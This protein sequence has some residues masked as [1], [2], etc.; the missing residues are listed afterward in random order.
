MME[1]H[2]PAF[3]R[4][5]SLAMPPPAATPFLDFIRR[6]AQELRADDRAPQSL[7]Q[8]NEMRRKLVKNLQT[9]WGPFPQKHAPL[10]PQ[11]LGQL[12]RDGYRVEKIVFQTRPGV[13]MPANAYVPTDDR[14]A[15][16]LPAVLCVHGHWQG[17]KQDPH[18]QARC[19]G[20]AKLGFFVLAVD[21]LGAGERAVGTELGEYH[22]EMTAGTLWPTGL[23]LSGLQVYENMRAVDYLTS[24]PEVDAAKIGITGASGGGNQTMYAGAYDERFKAVVPVCSVGNYQAYLGAAC[25]MCEV[26][27]GALQ[28]TEEWGVLALVAPRALLVISATRDAHQFS[29]GEAKKS[30]ALAAPVFAL[31]GK[32]KNVRH[33]TFESPHDYNQ[34]MREAMYGWMTLHLKGQGDGA[35][36]TEPA[37]KMDDPEELRCYPGKSRAAQYM[38]IPRLAAAEAR[39]L[40][41]QKPVPDHTEFWESEAYMMREGLERVLGPDPEEGPLQLK[42]SDLDDGARLLEYDAEPGIR[43]SATHLPG[44]S[45]RWV[46]VVDPAGMQQASANEYAQALRSAGWNLVC[47]ELRACG[48]QGVP[49]DSIGNAPDHNT[50]EWSLWIGRPLLGQWAYD[51]RRTVDAVLASIDGVPEEIGVL[52][53]GSGGPIA[54]VA[55]A[56]DESLVRVGTTHALASYITEVPYRGQRLGVLSPGLLREVGDLPHLAALISP[57]RLLIANPIDGGGNEVAEQELESLYSY[58]SRVY[59]IR[60]GTDRLWVHASLNTQEFVHL[61]GDL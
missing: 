18:V 32:P 34:P 54:L 39:E 49:G 12:N 43:L 31:H 35:A 38:T 4:F 37:M 60:R 2:L 17:A 47:V 36:I 16:K 25:C 22:G 1:N 33:A 56:Q 40:I 29:V 3:P 57:R 21:A 44:E 15:G 52:G 8:W 61:F 46:I 11:E 50:A 30:L 19:I 7:E 26:V 51:V 6:S 45:K 53:L 5:T 58:P 55:A 24:R 23:A 10:E 28:F 20:L 41:E 14:V 42:V 13:L 9:A 27:P 48:K 59:G